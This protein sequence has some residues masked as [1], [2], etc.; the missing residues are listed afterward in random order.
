MWCH[1][2][3]NVNDN[4]QKLTTGAIYKIKGILMANAI[5]FP[6]HYL[7]KICQLGSPW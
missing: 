2:T 6:R 4:T 3:N 5:F 1:N 7:A